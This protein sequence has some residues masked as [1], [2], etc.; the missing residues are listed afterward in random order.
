MSAMLRTPS[1]SLCCT[2]ECC[3]SSC[4]S[5]WARIN[6]ASEASDRAFAAKCNLSQYLVSVLAS[7][8]IHRG[9][10]PA[11]FWC[12]LRAFDEFAICERL[13]GRN[14]KERGRFPFKWLFSCSFASSDSVNRVASLDWHN[15]RVNVWLN[16]SVASVTYFSTVAFSL[17]IFTIVASKV[18]TLSACNLGNRWWWCSVCGQGHIFV[19]LLNKRLKCRTLDL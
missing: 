19:N 2:V 12:Q 1:L 14:K 16:I 5:S 13:G 8:S 4:S 17:L 15:E 9:V 18:R 3:F 6:L 7:C 10:V 11:E